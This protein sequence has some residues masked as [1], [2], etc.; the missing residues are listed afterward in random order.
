MG[1]LFRLAS[2]FGAITAQMELQVGSIPASGPKQTWKTHWLPICVFANG[3]LQSKTIPAMDTSCSAK[4]KDRIGTPRIAGKDNT[5]TEETVLALLHICL[6][7]CLVL[8][9]SST[10]CPT[11]PVCERP[12]LLAHLIYLCE[13]RLA[14]IDENASRA[15]LKL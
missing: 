5:L 1:F 14:R 12:L 9:C 2:R 10:T 3:F 13:G 11:L 7:P 15:T 4:P 6:Q 8:M